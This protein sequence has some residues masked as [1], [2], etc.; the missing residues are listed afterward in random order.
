MVTKTFTSSP[1]TLES[2]LDFM[3]E[4]LE[5]MGYVV[6]PYGEIFTPDEVNT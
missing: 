3:R 1:P 2:I 4:Q 6:S 5:R